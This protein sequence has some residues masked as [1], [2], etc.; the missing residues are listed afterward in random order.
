MLSVEQE[1]NAGR[2][3]VEA[4]GDM[5]DDLVD[6]LRDLLVALG[7]LLVELVDGTALLDGVEES[8]G[9]GHGS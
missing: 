9:R 7:R 3:R 5:K 4:G 8:L 2:L 1:D 6:E